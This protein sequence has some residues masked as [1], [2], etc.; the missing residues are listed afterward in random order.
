MHLYMYV[1]IHKIKKIKSQRI[2]IY[3]DV[4]YLI[5]KTKIYD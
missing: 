5:C 1:V 4:V 2:I 3:K